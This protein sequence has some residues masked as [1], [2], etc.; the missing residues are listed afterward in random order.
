MW[1]WYVAHVN[2]WHRQP[3]VIIG[4][5][6]ISVERDNNAVEIIVSV[7]FET[8]VTN[9]RHINI[10]YLTLKLL[11]T[12]PYLPNEHEALLLLFNNKI[13]HWYLW[14]QANMLATT[15]LLLRV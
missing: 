8:N 10:K 12:F 7:L 6:A 4:V 5:N 15:G 13:A 14:T 3:Y 9:V 1:C 2:S 11:T